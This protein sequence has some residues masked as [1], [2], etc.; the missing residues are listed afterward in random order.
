MKIRFGYLDN[1]HVPKWLVTPFDM[2]IDNKGHESDFEDELIEMHVDLESKAL[3]KSE[4]ISEYSSN[5][6]TA[7][8]YSKHR[9]AAVPFLPSLPTPYMA[10]T[11]LS[12]VDA[13]IQNRGTDY[14]C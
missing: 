8:K 5:I 9:A 13:I 10:E 2:K 6:N 1:M 3:F 14:T 11:D 7:I 4:N 12:H